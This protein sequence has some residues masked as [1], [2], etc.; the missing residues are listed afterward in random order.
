ME[1]LIVATE[2]CSCHN[3][4]ISFINNLHHNGLIEI[5]TIDE[6]LFL[7]T[8]QLQ[9]IEKMMH[10]HYDLEIN[11]EGI[12]AI[13]HLLDKMDNLQKNIVL[14]ENKLRLYE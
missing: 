8:H 1:N 14:L 7:H 12:D 4:E 6:K 10:L 3:I 2:F 9:I 5:T 13:L 11:I